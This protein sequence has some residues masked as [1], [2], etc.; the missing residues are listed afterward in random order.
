MNQISLSSK[1]LPERFAT[2]SMIVL[3]V[4]CELPPAQAQT[5]ITEPASAVTMPDAKDKS[6]VT[7]PGN[8]VP[9]DRRR[10]ENP[11]VATL[12]GADLQG[13]LDRANIDLANGR[14]AQAAS[15]AGQVLERNPNSEAAML[16][17]VDALKGA[18]QKRAALADADQ[19]VQRM[20]ANPLL[21]SQRGYLRREMNDLRG[22]ADDFAAA[23]AGG[24]LTPDQR[25]NVEAG[26]SEARSAE[27]QA[28]ID[29]ADAALK[30]RD[31]SGASEKSREALR[32]NPKSE[33][34][35]L[36]RV[37]ALAQ[38]GAKREAVA[39]A[40]VF[41]ANNRASPVLRAQRGYL[42][43]ELNDS[44]GA[45]AD[46]TEALTGEGLSSEQRQN[47]QAA[48]AEAQ[49]AQRD[50]IA[51][52]SRVKAPKESGARAQA[53]RKSANPRAP[54]LDPN[55]DA[56]IRVR[57]ETLT[58]AGQR[59]QAQ[60]EMDRLM[61]RGRAPAWAYA[62]RGFA[63]RDAEDYKGAVQDFDVALSRGDLDSRAAPNV[64]YARAEAAAMLAE[65]EGN[66][67]DAEASYRKFLETEP[68]QADGWF[69]LGY[70]LLQQKKR[71]EGADALN[72]GLELRPVGTAYLDAA[73]AYIFAN[74]PLASAHYRRGLDR[75]YAGDKSFV[76]RSAADMERV[77]NE[78]VEAD[79]TIRTNLS[80]GGIAGRP[81]SA[82]G[83]N[84]TFGGETR[85]RFDGR[86]LPSVDGLEA[87]VRGLSGKDS[88]GT[89]E[90]D[91]AIGLRYRP[92]HN[93][94]LYVGGFADHFFEPDSTTQ[95]V[96]NWGL[97]LG[98]DAYPYAT[99]WK[100]YW[101]FGTFGAWRTSD[102]RV[103]EDT[104]ANLGFLYEFRTPIRA[105]AGPT[106]LAVAGYDNQATTPWA[107][108]V[109]P[110][111]LSYFW[112]G[113]DKYRSYDAIVSVQFGYLFNVGNDERQ[114]GWRG[115]VGV[116]F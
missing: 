36:I 99:G 28:H 37:A 35:V 41:V 30:S 54:R 46:F 87:V 31:Y 5:A 39:E 50:E 65:R 16:I 77:K 63:R 98:S 75:Y 88:N 70:L 34:A 52:R 64:R 113:G 18:G 74:A 93:L 96:L 60:L 69:K 59:Q 114:Q 62:Q 49:T 97:G 101:D 72:K 55:S 83:S 84:N 115:Q 89:R 45:I 76:G 91:A 94:N 86:Y 82:G 9:G 47:V 78:V 71:P 20:A 17:R 92:I 27:V 7:W 109:G 67:L 102:Q 4:A 26:L 6:A 112:F 19:Y 106:V 15:E 66:P 1:F 90:T 107:A 3:A 61:A 104:R 95:F 14:Y 57:I 21:R 53:R 79:A 33:A 2:L 43:R 73:N 25:R 8:G 22:A 68:A 116:T 51:T 110:S 111:V 23:L 29:L 13:A 105:A 38:T 40:D 85:M 32:L 100:L 80:Y 24:G 48:L 12:L 108:G 42:R 103:L 58:R 11:I 10:I 56:A 44:D 81:V